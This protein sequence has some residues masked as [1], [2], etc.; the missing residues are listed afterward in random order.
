MLF[1]YNNI[2]VLCF[3]LARLTKLTIGLNQFDFQTHIIVLNYLLRQIVGHSIHWVY[4]SL[5]LQHLFQLNLIQCHEKVQKFFSKFHFLKQ[6]YFI[7]ISPHQWTK[8]KSHKACKQQTATK[9]IQNRSK[10]PF[11]RFLILDF[12]F[13]IKLYISLSH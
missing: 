4:L 13:Y 6:I 3:F 2:L 11:H 10:Q 9:H 1:K 7:Q 12:K 8:M 5:D